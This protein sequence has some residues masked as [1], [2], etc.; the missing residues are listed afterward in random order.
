MKIDITNQQNGVKAT[1][2]GF[3]TTELNSKI[4]AC[5]NGQCGCDCDPGVMEKITGIE[6]K[7]ESGSTT[8]TVS[9]DVDATTLAPMMESCLIGEKQ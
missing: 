4:E 1:L 2:T 8:L 3:S 5:Q 9:G 6:L 7:E